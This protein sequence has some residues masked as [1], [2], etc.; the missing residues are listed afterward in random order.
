MPSTG[1]IRML[2]LPTGPQVRW[3]GGIQ[4]GSAV[5]LYYDPMLAKLI[6][7][8]DDREQALDRLATA[9]EQTRLCGIE[10]NLE[11]LRALAR[12]ETVRAGQTTTA[13]LSRRRFTSA[14]Y[15][16]LAV[17]RTIGGS[18]EYIWSTMYCG[19]LV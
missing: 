5:S 11:Y 17:R 3:D 19:T 13:Y 6:A 7:H 16:S 1:Q 10:T 15:R 14:S 12:D 9:L 2:S 18:P 8:G 4:E